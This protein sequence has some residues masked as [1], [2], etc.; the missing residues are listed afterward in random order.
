MGVVSDW[1]QCLIVK[2]VSRMLLSTAI[3]KYLLHY[4]SANVYLMYFFRIIHCY[5]NTWFWS[6]CQRDRRWHPV[7]LESV[8]KIH[9]GTTSKM[10]L[11]KNASGYNVIWKLT[12]SI[13]IDVSTF[14]CRQDQIIKF[15]DSKSAGGIF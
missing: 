3:I 11:L 2:I 4:F 8:E 6:G 12:L 10:L 1:S 9:V 7:L 5:E 15:T 14:L 13:I